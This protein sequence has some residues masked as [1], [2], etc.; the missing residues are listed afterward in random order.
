MGALWH[1]RTVGILGLGLAW[2]CRGSLRVVVLGALGILALLA[3]GL[4]VIL[5]ALSCGAGP[6]SLSVSA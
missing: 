4:R 2:S 1:W 5:A 6:A 3:Q